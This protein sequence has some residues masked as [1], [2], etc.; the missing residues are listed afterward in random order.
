MPPHMIQGEHVF[1][2]GDLGFY[3]RSRPHGPGSGPRKLM[4]TRPAGTEVNRFGRQLCIFPVAPEA[5]IT[6]Q[7][8]LHRVRAMHRERVRTLQRPKT[9]KRK[10][11]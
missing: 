3:K 4:L 11:R 2:S 5:H 10:K 1:G 7:A 6:T 9:P 8:L